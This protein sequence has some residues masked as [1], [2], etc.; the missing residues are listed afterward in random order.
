[1]NGKHRPHSLATTQL[2]WNFVAIIQ[3][4]ITYRHSFETTITITDWEKNTS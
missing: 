4:L 3:I 2:G 1:M